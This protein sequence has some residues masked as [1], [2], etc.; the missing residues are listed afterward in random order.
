M[1]EAG[2]SKLLSNSISGPKFRAAVA[3]SCS[4]LCG[5][6]IRLEQSCQLNVILFCEIELVIWT[7]QI[8]R[9]KIKEGL[10][11]VIAPEYFLIWQA[12]ELSAKKSL[13]GKM[14]HHRDSVRI[15]IRAILNTD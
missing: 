14:E 8:R 4:R 13:M 15:V 12:F 9:V 6:V 1:R 10:R 3:V 5:T 7:A 2:M 11:A